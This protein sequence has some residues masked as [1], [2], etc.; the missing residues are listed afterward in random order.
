MLC[1]L[2]SAITCFRNLF[3]VHFRKNF[4]WIFITNVNTAKNNTTI[5]S[6][7]E[8]YKCVRFSP[9]EA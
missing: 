3:L 8:N 2:A 4:A 1:Y 5:Q 6:E 9:K 7:E